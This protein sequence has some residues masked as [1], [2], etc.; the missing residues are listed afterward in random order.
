MNSCMST[1]YPD[2]P[3]NST[4]PHRLLFP[5]P[6]SLSLS[7]PAPSFGQPVRKSPPWT[8]RMLTP[9][10]VPAPRAWVPQVSDPRP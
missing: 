6:S 2:S 8:R 3:I 1:L 9:G 5:S 10:P 7:V 4:L